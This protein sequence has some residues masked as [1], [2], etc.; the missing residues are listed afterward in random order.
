MGKTQI[1]VLLLALISVSCIGCGKTTAPDTTNMDIMLEAYDGVDKVTMFRDDNKI[2]IVDAQKS[3]EQSKNTY[4]KD[5]ALELP[6]VDCDIDTYSEDK[7]F[8]DDN[9]ISP[10]TYKSSIRQSAEYLDYL[11][12]TGYDV[13]AYY[14]SDEYYDVYLV[15]NSD[16]RIRLVIFSEKIKKLKFS[17]EKFKGSWTYIN[18]K[19]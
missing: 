10:D 11:K 6:Y 2:L 7:L 14:R 16:E 12:K 9:Y 13:K 5:K 19:G 3:V 1:K 18:E 4:T 17:Q 8:C 15:K